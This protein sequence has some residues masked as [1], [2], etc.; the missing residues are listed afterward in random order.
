[1]H[2]EQCMNSKMG[3]VKVS[4]S[5]VIIYLDTFLSGHL[6]LL[7]EIGLMYVA[8][9]LGFEWSQVALAL[10]ITQPEIEK[11]QLDNPYQTTKQII[12]ALIRWRDHQNRSNRSQDD[13]VKQLFDALE[14]VER[15]DIIDDLVKKYGIDV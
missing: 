3:N 14:I 12:T 11:I 15:R 2:N 5:V 10:G 9:K 4:R 6:Q 13:C 7:S 1:M 8:A